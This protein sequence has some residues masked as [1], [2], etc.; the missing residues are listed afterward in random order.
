MGLER[1]IPDAMKGRRQHGLKT[2]YERTNIPAFEATCR[3]AFSQ[4]HSA[5]ETGLERNRQAAEGHARTLLAAAESVQM[6]ATAATRD[7]GSAMTG[8]VSAPMSLEELEAR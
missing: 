4:S 8:S 1:Q 7:S 5:V 2:N 3:T 6:A